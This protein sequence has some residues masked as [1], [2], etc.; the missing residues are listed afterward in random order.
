MSDPDWLAP[1]GR[2]DDL[3]AAG[4]TLLYPDDASERSLGLREHYGEGYHLGT[5]W[6]ESVWAQCRE[7]VEQCRVVA[8]GPSRVDEMG[9]EL[10]SLLVLLGD[11]EQLWLAW[12][13]DLPASLWIPCGT[14]PASV[15]AALDEFWPIQRPRRVEFECRTRLFMGYRGQVAVPNPYSGEFVAAEPHDL[16]RHF[17]FSPVVGPR[18]WGSCRADDPWPDPAE[19]QLN[20]IDSVVIQ[21]EVTKQA[22]GGLCSFTRRSKYSGSYLGIE[23]HRGRLWVWSVMH[24]RSR[25]GEVITALQEHG[26]TLPPELPFDVAGAMM[27]FDQQSEAQVRRGLA[28]AVAEN[29]NIPAYLDVLAALLCMDPQ[30]AAELLRPFL[31]HPDLEVRGAVANIA[32]YYG[33][34]SLLDELR[35]TEPDPS[36]CEWIDRV[37]PSGIVEEFD[38]MGEPVRSEYDDDGYDDEDDDDDDDDEED[39]E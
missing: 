19:G 8:R 4:F 23:L 16:T 10:D 7:R 37:L 20:Q 30:A 28:D 35:L 25:H 11:R 31:T 15:K 26:I 39:P 2:D 3:R 33:W 1:L 32:T 6:L 24:P 9:V 21:R 12:N 34:L 17:N 38:D 14:T 13:P 36:L 18:Y 22:E 5:L 27:G 29:E